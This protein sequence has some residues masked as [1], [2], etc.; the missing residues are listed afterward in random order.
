MTN[1]IF[2]VCGGGSA[3]G[4]RR[5]L[6]LDYLKGI[7]GNVI[8]F[9][10]GYGLSHRGFS[11]HSDTS[12]GQEKPV[13]E[14][15]ISLSTHQTLW[16]ECWAQRANLPFL[17]QR[18]ALCDLISARACLQ[19]CGLNVSLLK[20]TQRGCRGHTYYSENV[21][22]CRERERWLVH[23]IKPESH[24]LGSETCVINGE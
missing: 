11:S 9:F 6:Q 7:K 8:P 1:F 21:E 17:P 2:A 3:Q 18:P 5:T 24:N 12:F 16:A 22:Y 19:R 20:I 13:Y 14:C 4:V 23:S 10:Q 15:P